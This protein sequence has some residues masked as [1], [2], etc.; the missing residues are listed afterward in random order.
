MED[1]ICYSCSKEKDKCLICNKK[2][3]IP[4]K[5]SSKIARSDIKQNCNFCEKALSA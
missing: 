5:F 2:S 3:N 4:V 1:G